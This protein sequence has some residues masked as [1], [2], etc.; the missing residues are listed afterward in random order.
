MFRRHRRALVIA[1]AVAGLG[2]FLTLAVVL[3][4]ACLAQ[5][6]GAQVLHDGPSQINGRIIVT[7]LGA[8]RELRFSNDGPRQSVI[9]EGKPLELVL[10][11]TR[12][13]MLSLAMVPS[14]KRVLIV[15]LGG[16]VMA[17]FL[18][19]LFPEAEID[20]VDIDPAVVEAATKHLGFK[21]DAKLKAIV[22]DGRKFTEESG[23]GYDLVF[24]DAYSDSEPP[25]H[26]TTV[27]YLRAVKGK[28]SPGGVVIGN[29]WPK[30]VNPY[31][32]AMLRTW[33]A[34]F[35][36]LCVVQ[37]PEARNIMFFA[38]ADGTAPSAAALE[39]TGA[40]LSK[41]HGLVFDLAQHA[42]QGCMVA[43][44]GGAVMKD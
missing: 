28:L 34:A 27:E 42:R 11:Y 19:T 23:G 36:G 25:R 41:K 12:T 1:N 39:Q 7:D 5:V 33:E 32:T 10:P 15:G 31:F 29:I 24:L 30:D 22:A 44:A 43:E 16:G 6:R 3:G 13:A 35:G 38:R 18:R 26:L 8:D 20:G 4:G 14:P 2:A 9:R 40:E 17:M 37:V 21:P